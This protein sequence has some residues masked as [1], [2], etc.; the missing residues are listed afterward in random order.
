[1]I[2]ENLDD[3]W[4]QIL[5]YW[6][7][8]VPDV[9]TYFPHDKA[10]LWFS[11]SQETDDY[12]SKTFGDLIPLAD[13]G[14][15]KHWEN[16]DKSRLALVILLDQFTRNIYRGSEQSFAYDPIALRVCLETIE[17]GKDKDLFPVERSFFYLPLEH[18]EDL[19]L[20]NLSVEKFQKLLEE[21]PDNLREVLSANVDYAI[22]HR[23]I[24]E[25][26]GRYP[27]RNEILGRE[28]SEEEMN[29]LSMPGSSF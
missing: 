23:E 8:K 19:S 11:K 9:P 15:L 29:F 21:S 4:K 3:R 26:F 1:M 18:S 7:A 27:H 13:S 16:S 24:I 22:K 14:V 12:I 28:S 10:K 17:K 2:R 5:N 6:F 20:Q 25:R